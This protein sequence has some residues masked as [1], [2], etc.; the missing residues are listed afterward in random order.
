VKKGNPD[1]DN[2]QN[3]ISAQ[4]KK[5]LVYPPPESRLAMERNPGEK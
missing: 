5:P 2:G 1:F 3:T 4:R